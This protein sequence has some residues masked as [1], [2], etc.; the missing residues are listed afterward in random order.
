[1]NP[2][3]QEQ[4]LAETDRLTPTLNELGLSAIC[5]SATDAA[6]YMGLAPQHGRRIK[7]LGLR[8]RLPR[9]AVGRTCVY[10]VSGLSEFVQGN[11]KLRSQA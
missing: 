3:R 2:V 8:G 1:M 5:L 10:P 6:L 4:N 9:L 7:N 11:T